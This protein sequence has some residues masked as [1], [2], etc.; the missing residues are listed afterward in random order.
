MNDVITCSPIPQNGI[1]SSTA[2]TLRLSP[3]LRPLFLR[4][5]CQHCRRLSY[6]KTLRRAAFQHCPSI[7]NVH[8]RVRSSGSHGRLFGLEKPRQTRL[9][10]PCLCN[11]LELDCLLL[12]LDRSLGGDLRRNLLV[13]ALIFPVTKRTTSTASCYL[14]QFL[15]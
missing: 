5:P 6:K 13:R 3:A 4:G 14:L 9:S 11:L 10:D 1:C 12:P 8:V 7:T 15:D 2:S